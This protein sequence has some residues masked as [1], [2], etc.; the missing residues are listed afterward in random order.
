MVEP[1]E[2]FPQGDEEE[3]PAPAGD[4]V[5]LTGGAGVGEA[6][7]GG[8]DATAGEAEGPAQRGGMA[9]MEGLQVV[10]SGRNDG[11]AAVLHVCR[12]MSRCP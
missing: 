2:E 5:E 3:Q 12:R 9:E 8:D 7:T 4:A 11:E 1:M 6:E 10:D